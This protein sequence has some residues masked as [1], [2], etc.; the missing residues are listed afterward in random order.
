MFN[1]YMVC[2]S[3][4]VAQIA[5]CDFGRGKQRSDERLRATV[6]RYGDVLQ[7]LLLGNRKRMMKL[8]TILR[9]GA[10]WML[11]I[12]LVTAQPAYAAAPYQQS[13]LGRPGAPGPV[14]SDV[15]RARR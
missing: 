12:G 3:Y 5:G 10:V 7:G 14:V 13:Q 9:T 11:C 8:S 1:L 4:T 15:A 2:Q 6:L